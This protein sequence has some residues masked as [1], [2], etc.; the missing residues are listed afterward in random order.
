M[1]E[2]FAA[3][4]SLTTTIGMIEWWPSE[5]PAK[6][7]NCKQLEINEIKTCS[8]TIKKYETTII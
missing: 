4:D 3:S 8:I 6:N 1:E 2:T 5:F 7:Y